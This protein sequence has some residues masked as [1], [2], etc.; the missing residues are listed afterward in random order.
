MPMDRVTM[1]AVCRLHGH[2]IVSL[3][4]EE[5]VE[6]KSGVLVPQMKIL[7]RKCGGSLEEISQDVRARKAERVVARLPVRRSNARVEP[8][9]SSPPPPISDG[10]EEELV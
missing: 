7:C 1:T 5:A 6:P 10:A 4:V 2:D 3:M 8:T 9:L